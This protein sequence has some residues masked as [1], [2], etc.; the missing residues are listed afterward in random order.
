MNSRTLSMLAVVG[1]LLLGGI[2][3]GLRYRAISRVAT[4]RDQSQWR[5]TY[6]VEFEATPDATAS[7]PRPTE[8]KLARPF[9]TRYCR[10]LDPYGE[11]WSS[12]HP[13]LKFVPTR[14]TY[15]GTRNILIT[16]IQASNY[17]ANADFDLLLS[18]RPTGSGAPRLENLSGDA[19][20]F[21]L[22]SEDTIPVTSS[23]VQDALESLPD[24]AVTDAERVQAIF[25]YCM[26]LETKDAG[27][28]LDD[29]QTTLSNKS[30]SSLARARAMVAMCRAAR[31]PA[32]LVAGFEI[33]QQSN[34]RT[35]RRW[36]EAFWS[37][38]WWPYDP[39]SGYTQ[40]LPP[41]FLPVRRGGDFVVLADLIGNNLQPSYSIVRLPPNEAL[42]RVDEQHPRR[43]LEL[44]RLPVP[45][46]D[47]IK[48]LLLLPFAALITAF[49]RNVVGLQTFGTFAPALLAM[50]FIYANLTYG[51][52]ILLVVVTVGLVGRSLLERLRLLM[53]PRLSIM[54]TL[55]ILC[56]VFG[57][58]ILYY[59]FPNI[60]AQAVLLPMVILTILIERFHVTVEED[61]L[62][63][64]L[65]LAVGTLVVAILSY[66]M[67]VRDEVG[68]FVLKFP[69]AHFFTIAAFIM[70][71]RYA[72]YRLTELWRFR[73][74]VEPTEI[75]R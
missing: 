18:S 66:A 47:V 53:V 29:V 17:V 44:D 40:T 15:T 11:P 60:S 43:I 31:V 21:F 64:S 5:L 22:R 19:R 57:I 62:I 26:S 61:G 30:G 72:G 42:L 12:I 23:A 10:I 8:V 54:L 25:E 52:M 67:L 69:E 35:P 1:F 6:K 73:D 58:S 74:L 38:R 34:M 2:S 36:V 4:A 41:N 55:V 3:L 56:V 49:M 14:E 28:G 45:M 51:I 20:S 33:R 24:D 16:T 7:P 63:Y 71:G 65:Q 37:Q 59:F 46:H 27:E 68:E 13:E 32:R 39:E 70:L 9:D 75:G 50:S 48:L